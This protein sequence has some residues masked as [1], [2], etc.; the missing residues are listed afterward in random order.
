MEILVYLGYLGTKQTFPDHYV[1][2]FQKLEPEEIDYAFQLLRG[3]GNEAVIQDI[4]KSFITD[5]FE[6]SLTAIKDLDLNQ[7]STAEVG[8]VIKE[9]FEPNKFVTSVSPNLSKFRPFMTIS[10]F[11]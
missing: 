9:V 2:R 3:T 6:D 7:M 1:Q 11:E 4:K 8:R 5:V 10:L